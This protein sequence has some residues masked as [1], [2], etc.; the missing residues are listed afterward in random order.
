DAVLDG[1]LEVVVVGGVERT[2]AHDHAREVVEVDLGHR[3]G[4]EAHP[5]ELLGAQATVAQDGG[6]L[7]VG[8]GVLGACREQQERLHGS[9]V[10]VPGRPRAAVRSRHVGAGRAPTLDGW[11]RPS[12]YARSTRPR[13]APRPSR[14]PSGPTRSPRDAATG[15]RAARSTR[16][17]TSSTSTTGSS[18]HPC[19]AGTPGSGPRS[20]SPTTTSRTSPG[21]GTAASATS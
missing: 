20:S 13:G 11:S 14:T 18:P 7:V 12:H 2:A 10:G 21:A 17:T 6:M 15:A 5:H 19:A 9:S 3:S 1:R 4:L 8:R 16:S